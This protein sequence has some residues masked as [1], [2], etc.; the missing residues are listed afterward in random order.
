[1]RHFARRLTCAAVAV[2]IAVITSF[3]AASTYVPSELSDWVPWVLEPHPQS[4]CPFRPSGDAR[5][6]DAPSSLSLVLSGEGGRF[7][8]RGHRFAPGW[9]TLPGDASHWPQQVALAGASVAVA[10][11]HGRPAV[12]LPAGEYAL[13]GSFDWTQLPKLLTI[14]DQTALIDL[15]VNGESRLH[16]LR[17]SADRV[18][19]SE[20]P[21]AAAGAEGDRLT[22]SVFRRITDSVPMQVTT[23]YRV[24]VS[25][26]QRELELPAPVM[27]GFIPTRVDAPLPVRFEPDGSMLVQV[28]PGR[29]ELSVTSRSRESRAR[30]IAPQFDSARAWPESEIWEFEARPDLRLV[31]LSGAASIDPTQVKLPEGWG[32][33]PTFRLQPGQALVFDV[34][35]RG[36]PEPEADQLNLHRDLWLDFDGRGYT[37][38][39]RI[40]GAVNRGWRLE[41]LPTTHLG[42]LELNEQP[43]LITRLATGGPAGVELRQGRVSLTAESRIARTGGEFSALGWERTFQSVQAR[44]NLPPGWSAF[45]VS[46]VD[47]VPDAWL[48]RWSLFDVFLVLVTAVAATRLWGWHWG[49]AF[50]VTLALMWHEPGAPRWTWI[51][52]IATMALLRVVGEAPR[53]R[54]AL[55]LYRT[56]TALVLILLLIP[57]AVDQIRTSFYPQLERPDQPITSYTASRLSEAPAPRPMDLETA[58]HGQLADVSEE[59]SSARVR[60]S[61]NA[62]EAG[63]QYERFD[64]FDPKA[65][66]QTGPGLPQWHWNFI[67]LSW[68]GPVEAGQRVSVWYLTPSVNSILNWVRVALALLLLWRL[69]TGS[70]PARLGSATSGIAASVVLTLVLAWQPKTA[71]A[72]YPPEALL[73]ELEARLLAPPRCLPGCTT[74]ARADL[75]VSE[76]DLLQLYL[77]IH[78][79]ESVAVPLPGREGHWQPSA[80]LVDGEAPALARAPEGT[81]FAVLEAGVHTLVMRGSIADDTVV[82]LHFPLVPK[83]VE[84]DAPGW[85]I[86]GIGEGGVPAAQLQLTRA[87]PRESGQSAWEPVAIPPF[88]VLER[89]FRIGLDWELTQRLKRVTPPGDTVVLQIPLL[90]GETVLSEQVPVSDGLAEV[91]LGPDQTSLEW[92]SSLERRSPLEL[93]AA[94]NTAWVEV[95]RFAVSPVWH[96]EYRGIAPSH[97]TDRTDRW[98]PTWHPWPGETLTANLMR[99]EGISGPTVTIEASE[100]TVTS[101][102]RATDTELKLWVRS[103]LGTR[104]RVIIPPDAELLSVA[105]DGKT[106]PLRQQHGEVIL[107]LNPGTQQAVLQ[108]RSSDSVGSVTTTPHIELGGPHVNA[109]LRMTLGHDRWILW[110]D[111]PPMGPA[112][113]FWGVAVVI[114]VGAIV[115]GRV[116]AVPLRA[117]HWALLGLGLSQVQLPFAALVVAWFFVLAYRGRTDMPTRALS[118]NAIQLGLALLTLVV[119][120]AIVAAVQQGLLGSPNMLVTGNESSAYQFNWY[121]DRWGDGYPRARVV[122]VPLIVYRLLMLAW[123]LWLAFA[124]VSWLRWGWQ[125]FARSGVYLP[126]GAGRAAADTGDQD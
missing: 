35:R 81:L 16:A 80:V 88:T 27:D 14:P 57:F 18:W 111:G 4:D 31:E 65:K 59:K 5:L 90:P 45:S 107:P 68:N 118:F 60:L 71:L 40:T 38:R 6:C 97:H 36:D 9:V 61:R 121:Q 51:N 110:A 13:T 92:R 46:G 15:S 58:E 126:R 114:V 47:N 54:K 106:Q 67:R 7:E 89:T 37:V 70:L 48:Q 123:A 99:P 12:W 117:W 116:R 79:T 1:M 101:G 29:W 109:A 56:A 103:S 52:L 105:I 125:Q 44:L 33:L 19:V 30:L 53:L 108:W 76:T 32:G 28:R 69:F 83:R 8:L 120:G 112:V 3:A 93:R 21:A 87:L 42:Y 22:L 104:R 75:R 113:L 11:W 85:E 115:L 10:E 124:S 20:R 55:Q 50:L 49:L 63:P 95:W 78:V 34:Q 73:K 84:T 43:Q 74:I 25:G 24:E 26:R 122:S 102:R 94:E 2:L 64:S 72:A 23:V 91:R 96:V 119:I 86:S 98:L 62:V 82:Q 66:L 41:A 77:E 17:P 39:D 100:L